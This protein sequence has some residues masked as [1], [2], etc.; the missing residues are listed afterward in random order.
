MDCAAELA[1]DAKAETA[2][3]AADGAPACGGVLRPGARAL[4]LAAS[5]EWR[6]QKDV[7]DVTSTARKLLL[8]EVE[9]DAAPAGTHP[10]YA[11][12][13]TAIAKRAAC[14]NLCFAGSPSSTFDTANPVTGTGE[15]VALVAPPANLSQLVAFGLAGYEVPATMSDAEVAYCESNAP[16][17][18]P[19]SQCD[20]NRRKSSPFI[21]SHA[22]AERRRF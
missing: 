4:L 10:F 13:L 21:Q 18:L 11:T 1:T 22:L 15:S 8:A 19:R 9:I 2:A 17:R 7:M 16:C 3:G 5:A 14:P 12:I 20:S 6:R